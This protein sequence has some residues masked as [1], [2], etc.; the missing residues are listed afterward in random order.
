MAYGDCKDLPRR[1]VSDKVLPDKASSFARHIRSDG[2]LREIASADY[3][4]F[5]K[6]M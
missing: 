3:L 4:F 2:Y 6:K 5:D 1:I